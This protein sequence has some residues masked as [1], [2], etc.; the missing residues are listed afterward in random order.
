MTNPVGGLTSS[1]TR[2]ALL[3]I[4]AVCV[5]SFAGLGCALA[6]SSPEFL[7]SVLERKGKQVDAWKK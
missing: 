6:V 7:G 2:G 3:S 4:L 5:L 1:E